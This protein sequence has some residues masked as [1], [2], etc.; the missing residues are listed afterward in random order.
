[1]CHGIR[2]K[3]SSRLA[4]IPA[5][6]PGDPHCFCCLHCFVST[7]SGTWKPHHTC[8]WCPFWRTPKPLGVPPRAASGD[9]G[10][11]K[12]V[13]MYPGHLNQSLL[14]FHSTIM[15][16]QDF[17]IRCG[18]SWSDDRTQTLVLWDFP[19]RFWGFCSLPSPGARAPPTFSGYF[20]I[21]TADSSPARSKNV[22]S[23]GTRSCLDL[24][25]PSPQL[26]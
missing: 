11:F 18:F 15:L 24:T 20:G 17:P 25:L 21:S 2:E 19:K 13:S 3:T 12:M 4:P 5:D 8:W 23:W 6:P 26:Y 7:A 1:M 16:L 14:L 22:L 10:N 9:T